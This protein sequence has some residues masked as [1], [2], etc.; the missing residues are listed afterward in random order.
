MYEVLGAPRTA[1]QAELKKAYF[2]RAKEFH[3]DQNKGNA[4]AASKFQEVAD[5][6]SVL[7]DEKRRAAYDRFGHAAMEQGGPGGF[8]AGP[9]GT[10]AQEV[11]ERAMRDLFGGAFVGSPFGSAFGGGG[12]AGMGQNPQ[13]SRGEDVVRRLEV[14]FKEALTG[15]RSDLKYRTHLP[16]NTCSGSGAKGAKPETTKCRACRGTGATTRVVGGF[17]QVQTAC[18]ECG[19]AGH[20]LKNPCPDCAGAGRVTGT[21]STRVDVPPGVDSGMTL[22]VSGRGGAGERGGPPGDLIVE[23]VVAQSDDFERDG[24]DV[25]SNVRVSLVDAVLGAT[26]STQTVDGGEI[27]LKVPPGTNHGEVVR[28]RNRGFPRLGQGSGGGRGDHFVRYLVDLPRDLTEEQ[29]RLLHEFD[30]VERI[31][32]GARVDGPH[33]KSRAAAPED[34]SILG[35]I[36]NLVTGSSS[37]TSNQQ[38]S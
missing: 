28:I 16:C 14:S 5:A 27:E 10:N 11:F 26:V 13:L 22:R 20:T 6:W 7:G 29:K 3:P 12:P 21:L 18:P 23:L 24:P 30:R 31:K 33:N 32:R 25:R 37:S 38:P 36:K 8:G 15:V 19:G 17:M 2:A 1:T 4:T 34:D 9:E 35:R